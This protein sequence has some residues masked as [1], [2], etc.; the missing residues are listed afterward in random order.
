VD[1]EKIVTGKTTVAIISQNKKSGNLAYEKKISIEN[2]KR[3]TE[4]S[5]KV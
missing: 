5:I 2:Y 4:D 1:E 3:F